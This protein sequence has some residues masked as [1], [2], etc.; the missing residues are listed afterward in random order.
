MPTLSQPD[1]TADIVC[2]LPPDRYVERLHT[3]DDL[4]RGRPFRVRR[5]DGWVTFDFADA[6]A[7]LEARLVELAEAEKACCGFLGFAIERTDGRIAL[8]IQ[9]PAGAEATLDGI[10]WIV[11]AAG[12]RPA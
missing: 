10:D 7:D 3:I 12:G 8:T 6:D 9:A 11:R 2:T 4:V 5:Q 1:P